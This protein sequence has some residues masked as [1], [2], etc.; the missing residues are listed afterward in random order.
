M[1]FTYI[2]S[3]EEEEEEEEAKRRLNAGSVTNPFRI[4]HLPVPIY[5]TKQTSYTKL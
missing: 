1:S 4:I 5:K 3:Q 2:Q